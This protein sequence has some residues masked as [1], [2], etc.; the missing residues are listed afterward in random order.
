M[1]N[2]KTSPFLCTL[3]FKL[4]SMNQT[5]PKLSIY[6]LITLLLLTF[7]QCSEK[8][9]IVNPRIE[10]DFWTPKKR[11]SFLKNRESPLTWDLEIIELNME[12]ID[13]SPSGPFTEG[14]FPEPKYDLHGNFEGIGN[15][16]DQYSLEGKT[17]LTNSFFFNKSVLNE[18]YLSNL[19]NEVFFQ[20]I[21]LTD[22]VDLINYN[23][24][25]SIIISRNHPDYLGQGFY[26]T[27]GNRIDYS[28]FITAERQAFAIVNT[29]LFDLSN[30]KTI[31]IAPQKD[32]SLR[33]LQ[34]DSPQL[35]RS[36][37][38]MYTKELI[39]TDKVIQFFTD[40]KCI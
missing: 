24:A 36:E 16:S 15:S 31:L 21:V 4:I 14:V 11:Q 8:H 12:Y 1:F 38:E 27:K 33:S 2:D 6:F 3:E 20:I 40:T 19:P 29:R 17:I 10:D 34:I 18:K 25:S 13:D 7:L 28:A 37:L 30:G 9:P 32:R 35:S 5:L 22:T 39:K 23:L 26:K